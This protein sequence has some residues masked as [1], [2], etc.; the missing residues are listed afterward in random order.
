MELT[1]R[2]RPVLGLA[3]WVCVCAVL[4]AACDFSSPTSPEPVARKFELPEDPAAFFLIVEVGPGHWFV[5]FL[6]KP[7]R[8]ALTVEGNLFSERPANLYPAPILPEIRRRRLSPSELQEVLEAVGATA[9]PG[10]EDG[11]VILEPSD[12][13]A[14][15]SLTSLTLVQPE[16]EHTIHVE[17]LTIARHTDAR[18]A[19]LL[20]LYE[21][22][23]RLAQRGESEPYAG[24]R[25]EVF[26]VGDAGPPETEGDARDWP[27]PAPPPRRL[28]GH[29]CDTYED[30]AAANLLSTFEK[31]FNSARWN[32][33]GTWYQILARSLLPGEGGCGEW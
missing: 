25:I 22:L 9:L 26:V 19:P 33:E 6:V 13:L 16:G 15:A 24:D 5:E 10:V 11:T 31:E 20:S 3:G 7:P 18:V 1:S 17:G 32:Y 4:F 29:T 8:H 21:L 23:D 27:L 12:L 28:V 2:G 30:E 14:D